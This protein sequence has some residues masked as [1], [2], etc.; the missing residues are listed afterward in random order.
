[1]DKLD[2]PSLNRK[3]READSRSATARRK[4]W[5]PPSK[6]DAPAAPPGYKH[7]WI[8]AEVS[9]YDDRINVASRLRE[10]YE[11]VRSDEY[12]DFL[13]T[14]MEGSRHTGVLGVG[15]LLLARI[16]EETVAERNAYYTSRTRDQLQ[17]VDNDL[18]KANAHD[19]MR[20][21]KPSR[22]SRTV[23]GS[24]KADE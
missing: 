16:P 10:G 11:L 3:S 13:G 24:P 6:L 19:S 12:P 7:R 4:P 2:V 18:M 23:F 15:G 9:G 5:A 17:A 21:N 20:I 14:P 22:Q 8:R 1:M